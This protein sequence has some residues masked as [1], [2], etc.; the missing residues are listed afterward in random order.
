MAGRRVGL[1]AGAL[2][3]L[4]PLYFRL[5]RRIQ[6]DIAF[7]AFCSAAFLMSALALLGRTDRERRHAWAL[8]LASLALASLTKGVLALVL[9]GGATLAHALVRRDARLLRLIFHPLSIL[10]LVAPI[11]AWGLVLYRE[12]GSTFVFEHFVNNSVGRFLHQRFDAAGVEELAYGDVGGESA[13]C[14]YLWKLPVV[15][16]PALVALVAGLWSW[17]RE[18]RSLRTR[19][20]QLA[21]LAICYAFAPPLLLSFSSQKG[22]HHLG[23]CATAWVVFAA[24]VVERFLRQRDRSPRTSSALLALWLPGITAVAAMLLIA[25]GRPQGERAAWISIGAVAAIGLLLAAQQFRAHR[26]TIGGQSLLCTC[27]ALVVLAMAPVLVREDDSDRSADIFARW[28][29]HEVGDRPLGCLA[30]SDGDLGAFSFAL[31]R[32]VVPIESTSDL[33]RF[34]ACDEPRFC[35]GPLDDLRTIAAALLENGRARELAAGG[36]ETLAFLVCANPRARLLASEPP[37]WSREIA[38][39]AAAKRAKYHRQKAR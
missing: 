37:P 4:A 33:A 36:T 20:G 7:G 21:S 29:A 18:R 14:Y 15:V 3:V 8:C 25:F 9:F 23:I 17:L 27:A 24:I 31:G 12:G 2:L 22:V 30:H 35:V 38:L 28:L 19:R 34:L 32:P 13:A 10:A 6:L 16:G 26:F 39:S 11:A 5:A 1:L